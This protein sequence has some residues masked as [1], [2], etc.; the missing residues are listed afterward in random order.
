MNR[1]KPGSRRGAHR[2]RTCSPRDGPQD[3]RPHPLR[4][5][6]PGPRRLARGHRAG[7]ARRRRARRPGRHRR[8]RRRPARPLPDHARARGPRRRART[9]PSAPRRAARDVREASSAATCAPA[10]GGCES[11]SATSGTATSATST[12]SPSCATCRSSPRPRTR[13]PQ[14]SYRSQP[15]PADGPGGHHGR[16]EPETAPRRPRPSR[17]TEDRAAARTRRAAGRGPRHRHQRAA[18]AGS[19]TSSAHAGFPGETATI[20]WQAFEDRAVTWT[21]SRRQRSTRRR[22]TAGAL[23]YD[24][25]Y[26]WPAFPRVSV[27][28]G[29]TSASTCSRRPPGRSRPPRTWSARS[30]RSPRSPRPARTLTIVTTPLKQ[31]ATIQTDVPNIYLEQ[32]AFNTVDRE[33]PHGSRSTTA[34]T[35]WCWT[36]S[37]RPGSRRPA[38]TRCSSAIRKAM[39]TICAAGLQPR[40][41]GPDAGER[42][43]ARHARVSG[44]SGGTAD[45]VFAPGQFAPDTIFG[46]NA[47]VSKTVAAAVVVDSQ[48]FGKLYTS[49]G[50]ARPVRGGR[51]HDEHGQ[52]PAGD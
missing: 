6:D 2:A 51:R 26:V 21:G 30:T 11:S 18:P 9:G 20:A 23:G 27:D 43:G 4:R 50:D 49:P 47:R 1:P 5:R 32:P 14:S 45:F 31:V 3:P 34:S 29:A 42:R 7:R 28:G 13:R 16:H 22:G 25:R 17:H 10:R 39:T 37:P 52:R 40:H 46:L 44:V 33:R 38:P 36:R 8:P 24:Q 12:R 48:A 35:S 19:P 15:D 41:A